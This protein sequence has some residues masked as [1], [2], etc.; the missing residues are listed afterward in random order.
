MQKQLD[1]FK[2]WRDR[3]YQVENKRRR[4]GKASLKY[5]QETGEW[6]TPEEYE[7]RVSE[8]EFKKYGEPP[9]TSLW[10]D[11]WSYVATGRRMSKN[12]LKEYCKRN[13]KIWE[14]A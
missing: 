14:N 1:D 12:Q 4:W 2:G 9:N 7:K 13:G 8:N 6:V 11:E 3:C 5:H 10:R